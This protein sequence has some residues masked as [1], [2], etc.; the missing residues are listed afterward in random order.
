MVFIQAGGQ[1]N[2]KSKPPD[3][4]DSVANWAL[5]FLRPTD[6]LV[7]IVLQLP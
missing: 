1:K 3:V 4:L 2:Y 6:H 7:Q 5:P